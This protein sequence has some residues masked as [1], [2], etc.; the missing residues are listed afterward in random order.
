[1]VAASLLVVV[2]LGVASLLPALRASRLR[3]VESLAHV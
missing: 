1:M 2:T 3:I